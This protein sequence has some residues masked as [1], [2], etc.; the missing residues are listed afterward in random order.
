LQLEESDSL[1]Q[2]QDGWA[3]LHSRIAASFSGVVWCGCVFGIG[4]MSLSPS[5]PWA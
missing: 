4:G 1:T 3:R 5:R 2:P